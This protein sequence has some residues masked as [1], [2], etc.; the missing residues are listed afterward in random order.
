MGIQ[1][2]I[3]GRVKTALPQFNHETLREFRK[4]QV[5]SVPEYMDTV[6]KEVVKLFDGQIEYKGYRVLSPHERLKYITSIYRNN[7]KNADIN[8][9]CLNLVRYEFKLGDE[10]RYAHLNLPHYHN[11]HVLISGTEYYIQF[12]IADNLFFNTSR[13]IGLKV[14]RG[15]IDFGRDVKYLY[16]SEGGTTYTDEV[17][18]TK[19]HM[20]RPPVGR[21]HLRTTIL[22]YLLIKFGLHET[23]RKF[24]IDPVDVTFAEEYDKEDTGHEYFRVRGVYDSEDNNEIPTAQEL[25]DTADKGFFLRVNKKIFTEGT[26]IQR[27]VITSLVYNLDYFEKC[28]S[29]IWG[30]NQELI[31]DLTHD[32]RI[33]RVILGKSIFG[34]SQTQETMAYGHVNNHWNTFD[35]SY[36]DALTRTKLANSGIHCKDIYDVL[37]Y[38]FENIDSI[39][40]NHVPMSLYGKRLSVNDILLSGVYNDIFRQAYELTKYKR[41]IVIR[42]LQRLL[43]S[44]RSGIAKLYQHNTLVQSSPQMFNTNYLLTIGGKKNRATGS[45]SGDMAANLSP[46]ARRARQ[47]TQRNMTENPEYQ[48]DVSMAVVETINSNPDGKPGVGGSLGPYCEIDLQTGLIKKPD[49]AKPL[50][51]FSEC[52][53]SK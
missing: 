5:N 20:R 47:N 6:Y 30:N 16:T 18:T 21:R 53:R 36:L 34:M 50:D 19:I 33:Y 4:D 46:A 10:I 42:D 29:T 44:G 28:N 45:G 14:M 23:L 43:S 38:V 40:I 2:R 26:R 12:V 1:N 24:D 27:R 31:K 22:I 39:I 37:I 52:L 17:I 32:D 41:P 35:G 7:I 15:N 25:Q 3:L 51:S 48:A 13:G 11:D 8:P 9:S 49:F